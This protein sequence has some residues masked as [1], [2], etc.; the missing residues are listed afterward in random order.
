MNDKNEIL[1]LTEAKG[2]S[3]KLYKINLTQSQVF[4]ENTKLFEQKIYG[5]GLHP[6]INH[7]EIWND[8]DI[9]IQLKWKDNYKL[10]R[11]AIEEKIKELHNFIYCIK[12]TLEDSPYYA[13]IDKEDLQEL[14]KT[15]T[16]EL[17]DK[18]EDL[19]VYKLLLLSLKNNPYYAANK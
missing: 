14:E 9:W 4:V 13:D 5:E 8:P 6:I 12:F 15:M 7:D 16:K 18:K 10:I 2:F 3:V 11:A 17:K 19:V 1:Y